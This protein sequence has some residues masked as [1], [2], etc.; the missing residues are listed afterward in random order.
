MIRNCP[1]FHDDPVQGRN[2]GVSEAPTAAAKHALVGQPEA[3]A[4]KLV[5]DLNSCPKTSIFHAWQLT[6]EIR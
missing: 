1:F 6:G 3:P 2:G 4:T 5:A